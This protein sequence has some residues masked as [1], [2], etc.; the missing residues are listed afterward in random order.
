MR[1]S[2]DI[3]SFSEKDPFKICLPTDSTYKKSSRCVG[4]LTR[5]LKTRWEA[6][7]FTPLATQSGSE[8]VIFF[9]Q[10]G[11]MR[12]KIENVLA[13]DGSKASVT[14]EIE[15]EKAAETEALLK[16]LKV[17]RAAISLN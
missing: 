15:S 6:N 1:I 10:K 2:V 3:T 14:V 13:A 7:G 5:E 12:R 11:N 9:F 17:P 4:R 16:F 8:K